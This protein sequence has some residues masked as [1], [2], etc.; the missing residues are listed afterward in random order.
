[1]KL[2]LAQALKY[3]SLD[4]VRKSIIVGVY[5]WKCKSLLELPFVKKEELKP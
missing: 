4:K 5:R 1:M 2:D 3:W